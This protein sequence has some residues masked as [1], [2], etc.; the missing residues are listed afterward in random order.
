MLTEWF[1]ECGWGV[2]CHYL[3]VTPGTRGDVPL[4]SEEWNEQVDSFDVEGLA[5]QLK[6]VDAKYF[7]ITLGQGSGHYCAPN[8]TYDKLTGIS[9]SKC[10]KR[11]LISDIHAQL[12]PLGIKLFVYSAAEMSWGD[13]EA[14]IGLKMTHHHNDP[15][16]GGTKI[17]RTHRQVE[18]MKNVE[19]IHKE[20]AMRWGRKVSGWWIDGCYESDY[21]FPNDNPPNFETFA[22]VL[23]SGNPSAIVA[24]NPGVRVP[25]ICHTIYEDYTAGEIST[26]LPQCPGPWVEKDGHKARY[27]VLSY[28][29][30]SWCQ[31]E[32]R[33]PDELVAGYTKH[34]ISQGG[35]ISWD[36]PIQ[37]N[38]LIPEAFLKQLK[39]IGCS[40]QNRKN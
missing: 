16:S 6:S 40:M 36:V 10:S 35:V 22:A 20:W 29:G 11:D 24:F 19:A 18:F 15:D 3:A 12:D 37:K 14:R 38:G 30:K 21:R 23:R 5:R 2:F 33:F 39:S 7:V 4:T 32:P 13:A 8:E 9:S 25:V 1:A 31:G 17:W 26:A 28:L 27:H 34:I